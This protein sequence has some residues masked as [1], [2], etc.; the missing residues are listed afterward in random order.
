M[1]LQRFLTKVSDSAE[2]AVFCATEVLPLTGA[3]LKTEFLALKTT[4]EPITTP[5]VSARTLTPSAELPLLLLQ[6][7]LFQLQSFLSDQDFSE[8]H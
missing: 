3:F 6:L 4:A 2:P 5:P 1:W 7:S 8:R